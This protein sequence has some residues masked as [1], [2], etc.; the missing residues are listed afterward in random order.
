MKQGA[1]AFPRMAGL[2]V[3]ACQLLAGCLLSGMVSLSSAHAQAP[4]KPWS[5]LGRAATAA[6]VAAW[7]IDVRADFKG[8]PAGRGSVA[9]GQEVWEAQCESC[10]G[11]FGESNEVFTPIVG[12][13]SKKD[14]ETGR[15]GALQRGDYPQRTTLMKV[16]Q[17]STLW[18][19]INRAMPW[20]A[21]KSLSVEEV[22][23]VTAYILHLGD[24]VPADFVLSDKNIA[25]VQQRLP[26][27]NG[28]VRYEPM[29]VKNGKPDVQ[30]SLCM[31]A[32]A[33][34]LDIR[35]FLP[36]YARNAHGN[37]AEQHRAVGPVRGAD[38]TRAA[39]S[40]AASMTPT[41]AAFTAT[42]SPV[43]RASG[44]SPAEL[45]K[46]SNCTACHAQSAR[47]VGPSFKDIAARYK[48]DPQ[49]E[50]KLTGKVRNGAQGVWGAIPMPANPAL[51]EEEARSLVRWI[52]GGL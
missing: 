45:A 35:S 41:A 17:L 48:S 28:K 42:P 21:P 33:T 13:T 3:F 7:D 9:K 20:N 16:S 39:L 19:Y 49:A 47:L 52:L 44:K 1:N 27:R 34:E 14:I 50:D 5:S 26:N 31:S 25:Q 30:G 40:P 18:D 15:V 24:I 36:D 8:L 22:Y 51:K 12:G 37:L 46:A 43:P 38:T 23:A 6:E 32:C 10:H 2:T 29:W 11:T 4:A